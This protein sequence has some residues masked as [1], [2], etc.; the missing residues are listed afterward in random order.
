M[1]EGIQ[2]SPATASRLKPSALT[3]S[4][5][6]IESFHCLKPRSASACFR[7]T[8]SVATAC[9]IRFLVNGGKVS[10]CFTTGIPRFGSHMETV[11]NSR[12]FKTSSTIVVMACTRLNFAASRAE[13]CP[14]CAAI[15]PQGIVTAS[16]RPRC[17]GTK[18]YILSAFIKWSR[19][20]DLNH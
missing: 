15:R 18:M 10:S 20:V 9:K 11:S 1:P 17:R 16:L 2:E 5:A 4:Y 7:V 3:L 13:T 19:K 6:C 14:T 8:G 12:T